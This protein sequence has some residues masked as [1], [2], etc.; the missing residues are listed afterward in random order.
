VGIVEPEHIGGATTRG[1]APRL[2]AVTE[3]LRGPGLRSIVSALAQ[4]DGGTPM[5]R[6]G[7]AWPRVV[8][9][10]AVGVAVLA[11]LTGLAAGGSGT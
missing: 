6:M 5:R 2:L 8:V 7:D 11:A 10:G 4:P 3:A 1:G 9:A